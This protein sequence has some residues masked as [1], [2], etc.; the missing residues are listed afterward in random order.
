MRRASAPGTETLFGAIIRK[1][2]KRA[3]ARSMR[4]PA[5]NGPIA[6]GL[7]ARLLGPSHQKCRC[8]RNLDAAATFKQRAA[9]TPSLPSWPASRNDPKELHTRFGGCFLSV[10]AT[11]P[12]SRRREP[13]KQNQVGGALLAQMDRMVR[14]WFASRF[15]RAT[16]LNSRC[17]PL[18]LRQARLSATICRPQLP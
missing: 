8:L 1:G 13:P 5:H 2:L 17:L 6:H 7:V 4:R 14:V 3:S 11:L 9:P 10:R 15:V 16:Q 18:S 12:Y